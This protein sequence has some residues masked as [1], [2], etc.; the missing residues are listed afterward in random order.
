MTVYI[1]VG[2]PTGGESIPADAAYTVNWFAHTDTPGWVISGMRFRLMTSPGG[3][4]VIND[5]TTS[6]MVGLGTWQAGRSFTIPANTMTPGVTYWLRLMGNDNGGGSNYAEFPILAMPIT[7][8]PTITVPAVGATITNPTSTV[9]W[10]TGVA[11][12]HYQVIVAQGGVTYYD[13]GIVASSAQS[14]SVPFP[15]TGVTRG[16]QVRSRRGPTYAWSAW[17]AVRSVTVTHLPPPTPTITAAAPADFPAIGLTHQIGLTITQP[18]PSGGQPAVA[19]VEYYVRELGDSGNGYLFYTLTFTSTVERYRTPTSG[20]TY[21]F[22]IRNVAADGRWAYS[23]WVTMTGA[24]AL[25]GVLLNTVDAALDDPL[26]LRYNGDEAEDDYQPEAALIQYDGRA[27]PVVEF[28]TSVSRQLRVNV[29]MKTDAQVAALRTMLLSRSVICYRDR[30]GRKVWAFVTADAI[31]D[32]IYGYNTNLTITA[33]D[34][35]R[36]RSP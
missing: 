18:A 22:R 35:S 15:D 6:G 21:Q 11:Q 16:I 28:G 19:S 24:I 23:A 7:T 25:K 12:T 27:F 26:L 32:T 4:D 8:T 33:V 9:T 20:K 14:I 10:T 36:D 29:S 13:S 2:N 3:T 34:Y 5:N 30:R 1:G 31:V 17:S